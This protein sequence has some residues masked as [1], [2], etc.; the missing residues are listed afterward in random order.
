MTH[1]YRPVL[2]ALLAGVFFWPVTEARAQHTTCPENEDVCV[3]EWTEDGINPVRNALRN[4]VME[5]TNRPEGRTYLLKRGG[6]YWNSDPIENEDFHL[7]LIGETAEEADPEEA[8]VCGPNQDEDCGP[9]VI[10][11]VHRGDGSAPAGQMLITTGSQADVTMRNLWLFGQTDQGGLTSYEPLQLDAS[12]SRFVFDNVIFDRNDW[13]HIGVNGENNDIFI[14]NSSFRNLFGPTQRWEGL[15]MRIEVGADTV[16]IENN[17]FLNIGFTPYQ[18]EG[19]PANYV[20]INHNTIVNMGR[21]IQAGS[22]WKE[23][24]ITNNLMVN[25]FWHGEEYEEYSDPER[26]DP[27]VGVFSIADLPA[28]FGTNFGRAILLANN[29]MWR[30][31]Q[32]EDFYAAQ[33]PVMRAQPLVND[34]TL[35]WFAAYPDNMKMQDNIVGTDPQLA[36]YP[37][38]LVDDML[39]YIQTVILDNGTIEDRADLFYYDPGRDEGCFV[40]NVWPLPEDFSYSSSELQSAAT[41]GLPIGDLNWFPTH[42][43]TFENNREQYVSQ[44][45]GIIGEVEEPELLLTVQSETLE[46]EGDAQIEEPEGFKHFFMEG[47]GFI[48]WTFELQEAGTYGI[49]LHTNMRA[50][51][52]RGQRVRINGTNLRN[53]EGFGEY[54]FCTAAQ[55]GC[56]DPLPS[57]EWTTV[58]IRAGGLVEGASGLELEAGEHTVRV[59]PSW[60]WQGFSGLDIVDAGGEPVVQLTAVDAVSEGVDEIC[61][62]ADYCPQGFQAVMLGAGGSLSLNLDEDT[63]GQ[64]MLRVFYA[65]DSP[66]QGQ[67]LVNDELVLPAVTFAADTAD[68]FTD[69]FSMDSGVNKITLASEQGGLTVDYVQVLKLV[70]TSSEKGNELPEGFAL[71]QNYP[72][73]FNPSTTIQYEMGTSGHARIMIYDVL[74]RH[75]RTLVNGDMPA[76]VHRVTWDGRAADGATVASGVYLYRLEAGGAFKVRTMVML[77]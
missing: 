33:D 77:K 35:G 5:D 2:L 1:N 14:T 19:A 38:E 73:P 63:G 61:D 74:G 32:F 11:R 28:R 21:A 42:K 54:Y 52:Q 41:D 68:V 10:Q 8:F 65:A 49:D 76:G 47:S 53:N 36:T 24:Y 26:T 55:E 31:S 50:E 40:C 29:A 23:A 27:Y 44:I 46:L 16:V 75:V 71:E 13:H 37:D 18:S 6:L 20:R 30:D 43:E 64:Y 3:V 56:A 34:T 45:E 4:T 12:D 22:Q 9:A 25:P 62:D 60:G 72:N 58:E 69:L 70:G 48:E 67:V 51:T 59:E 39:A 7:R 17:T 66:T 15:G 57:N